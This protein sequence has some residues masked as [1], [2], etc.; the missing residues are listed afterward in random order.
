MM[1]R[2]LT[3]AMMKS[4]VMEQSDSVPQVQAEMIDAALNIVAAQGWR[5]VAID[6]KPWHLSV[7]IMFKPPQLEAPP[8]PPPLVY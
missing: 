4:I 6:T 3:Y 1:Y 5:L 8:S 2:T 7:Y